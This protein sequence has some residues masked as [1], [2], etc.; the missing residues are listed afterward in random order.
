[1]S[2]NQYNTVFPVK[3]GQNN[4]VQIEYT[5]SRRRDF[6]AANL[7]AGV[8]TTQKPPQGFTWHHLDDYNSATNKGSLQLV[9]TGAHEATY[10]HSGG[11]KQFE[12]FTGKT[13]K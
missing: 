13:Y 3:E 5:G 11:V 9:E 1:M 8:G 12:D 2:T 7:K 6:G 10:P 4:I